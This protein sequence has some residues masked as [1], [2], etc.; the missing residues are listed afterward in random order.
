MGV[1]SIVGRILVFTLWAASLG[2]VAAAGQAELRGKPTTTGYTGPSA[3]IKHNLVKTG[4]TNDAITGIVAGESRA[5]AGN[6]P[7]YLR[8][9]FSDVTT[10]APSS[11]TYDRCDGAHGDEVELT[12]PEGSF[13][14]G[15]RICLN[16]D[17]DKVKGIQLIT[18]DA[19][20]M[21]GA[22]AIYYEPAE[23]SQ[24]I[25]ISGHDYRLCGT[26]TPKVI[27]KSCSEVGT[28]SRYFERTN[29][30]GS[31]RGPDQDWETAVNC[32]PGRVATGMRLN[33]REGGGD[34]RMV[35]GIALDCYELT[36]D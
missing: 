1:Y 25:K 20:C 21:L 15:V 26:D 23:C 30:N 4:P 35:N 12:L 24:V 34:R 8:V 27:A 3:S 22:E 13:V 36:E 2:G 32:P 11:M 5:T 16:S 6:D 28:G 33:T 19:G 18:A 10:G 9:N 31:D 14:T 17:G 7:C 29:C